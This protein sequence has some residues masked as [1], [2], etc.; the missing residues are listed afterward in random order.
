MTTILVALHALIKNKLRCGLTVLGVVIGI[1][2]VT[3]MVSVGESASTLLQ[4]TIQSL[5]T[6]VIIVTPARLNRGGIR[7]G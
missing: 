1:A 4:N 3:T 2:A 6:N 7:G 5:G